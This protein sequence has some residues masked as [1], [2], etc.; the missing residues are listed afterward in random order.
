MIVRMSRVEIVG[1]RPLLLETLALVGM[2]A[3]LQLESGRSDEPG[4]VELL[5]AGPE[6]LAQ[7][8]R[9]ATLRSR[10]ARLVDLLPAAA[11]RTVWLDPQSA[12]PSV[13]ALIDR[14][15]Q[16]SERH[17][18][19]G[20]RLRRAARREEEQAILLEAL[21]G[22]LADVAPRSPLLDLLGITIRNPQLLAELQ[23]ETERLSGGRVALA[24]RQAANG[25]L[26]GVIAAAPELIERIRTTLLSEAVV[27]LDLPTELRELAPAR[28][29]TALRERQEELIRNA[30]GHEAALREFSRRW[31]G[32]Y[33]KVGDWIDDQLLLLQA[34]GEVRES[35]FCFFLHGWLPNERVAE[36]RNLLE[37]KLHGEVLLYE[38]ELREEDLA[39]APVALRNPPYLRPFELFLRLLPLP[40]YTSFDPT[41][42][43]GFGF[44]LLFGLMLGDAGYGAC[45]FAIAVLLLRRRHASQLQRDLGGILLPSAVSAILFGLVFGEL[46]GEQGAA[47]VGLHALLFPRSEAILP[48]LWLALG[49]GVAHIALGLILGLRCA[50][51]AGAR[52][53]ARLRLLH[54]IVVFALATAAAGL[55]TTAPAPL[56][57]AVVALAVTIPLLLLT[58]GAMAPL[59]TIKTIGNI[60]S[61]VRLMA[62]GLTS[63]LLAHV[64][65][66]LGGMTGNLLTGILIAG[67][68]HLFNLVLGVFAPTV[69]ALRLHYVEFFSK[70]FEPGG[71][72]YHPLEQPHHL[73]GGKPWK[74]P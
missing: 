65:N 11:V 28:Q 73:Q 38:R 70:F 26:V 68:L 2:T 40:R 6:V 69:H 72:S 34:A 39:A 57:T 47:V 8:L 53:E 3:A 37:E 12:L 7:R 24:T 67:T 45:L 21:Q 14:H 71:H 20:E 32:F 63:V 61:Y 41:P 64:A 59:E 15:L 27:E 66:T 58:G 19:E 13:A 10:I 4:E 5:C 31:L 36:L 50:L 52:H 23:H 16:E 9:L 35:E 46:F 42:L 49:V 48:L 60:V 18:S 54:L 33:L 62:I 55:A 56:A 44:P 1:P 29:A 51:L 22:L 25:T 30:A 17:R 43:L 74:K